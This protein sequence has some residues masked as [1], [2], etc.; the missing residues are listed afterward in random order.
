[1]S[2]LNKAAAAAPKRRFVFP[3]VRGKYFTVR[4]VMDE[5]GSSDEIFVSPRGLKAMRGREGGRIWVSGPLA[6]L[7]LAVT[8]LPSGHFGTREIGMSK[9]RQVQLGVA[10]FDPVILDRKPR[11][12]FCM[13]W[14]GK[15][16]TPAFG[17]GY[18]PSSA[19]SEA[20]ALE[21]PEEPK[22]PGRRPAAVV[23]AMPLVIHQ[24][25]RNDP[26]DPPTARMNGRDMAQLGLIDGDAVD[27]RRRPDGRRIRVIV[28]TGDTCQDGEIRL[29]NAV[30]QALRFDL[31]EYIIV[32]TEG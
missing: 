17:P 26:D 12:S 27:L 9:E 5:K 4:D 20:L 11:V 28:R 30:R 16:W 18:E 21:E 6:S 10:L 2:R 8:V 25:Y 24:G 7:S 3:L 23:D 1:M 19:D 22:Q 15:R 31:G 14:T 13:R 32:D 29:R